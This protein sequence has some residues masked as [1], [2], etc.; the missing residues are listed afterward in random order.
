MRLDLQMMTIVH[1]CLTKRKAPS[2]LPSAPA[3]KPAT[4]SNNDSILERLV[5]ALEANSEKE[6]KTRVSEEVKQSLLLG[7]SINGIT[8]AN[9]VPTTGM[10]IL[11]ST[12]EAQASMLLTRAFR[13][14]HHPLARFSPAQ[15]KAIRSFRV[16]WSRNELPQGLSN[17]CNKQRS[18]EIDTSDDMV[19]IRA[20][21]ETNT[22]LTEAE[23]SLPTKL[24]PM[25]RSLKTQMCLLQIFFGPNAFVSIM[26]KEFLNKLEGCE[27]DLEMMIARDSLFPTHLLLRVDNVI[28]IFLDAVVVEDHINGIPFS[29]LS[30]L[31]AIY[32]EI[33]MD[34]FLTPTVPKWISPVSNSSEGGEG[35]KYK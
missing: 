11:S 18:A 35:Y 33:A 3:K 5:A 10:A 14:L 7:G 22:P 32:L 16:S 23:V 30:E 13:K 20:K 8:P 31:Q 34:N 12:S 9:E 6:A 26:Y 27:Q 1:L 29:C 15:V 17:L 21:E 19:K 28:R 2:D 25:V 4:D 24:V